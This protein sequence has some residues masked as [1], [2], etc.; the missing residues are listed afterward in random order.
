MRASVPDSVDEIGIQAPLV[1]LEWVDSKT[2]LYMRKERYE[3]YEALVSYL[4][5][6]PPFIYEVFD[7][8]AFVMRLI[9][10]DISAIRIVQDIYLS[11]R[12]KKFKKEEEIDSIRVLFNNVL[13]A[14]L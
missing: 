14:L 1:K 8:G 7:N 12:V 13:L 6:N 11:V 2:L 4:D 10:V 9:D 5:T 3:P